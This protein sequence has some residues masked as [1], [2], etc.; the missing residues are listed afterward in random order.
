MLPPGEY[1]ETTRKLVHAAFGA[2][3]L[4]LRYLTWTQAVVLVAAALLFN[5][6]FLRWFTGGRVHRPLEAGSRYPRGIV[7]YP[8]SI[9]VLLLLFPQ[10]PDIVAAAWGILAAGDGAAT[11]AGRRLGGPRWPWNADKT[12]AGSAA[13]LI[14]GG[15]AGAA[16]AWWVRP[17]AVPPPPLW[18]S[19]GAPFAAALAAAAAESIRA[20]VDDNVTVPAAAALV[21]WLVDTSA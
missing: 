21:L 3:A 10:R 20:R 11:L 13:L 16:L 1:S 18:F 14:A 8:A 4:L 17:A 19:L 6:Y 7:L 5:V 12:V 2:G 15:A 9:L